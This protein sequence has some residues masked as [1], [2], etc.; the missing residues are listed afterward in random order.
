MPCAAASLYTNAIAGDSSTLS[1]PLQSLLIQAHGARA[2]TQA[3]AAHY[4]LV[5][6]SRNAGRA[7]GRQAWADQLISQRRVALIGQRLAESSGREPA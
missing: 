7:C 2:R 3:A 4:T 6:A 1:W 5:G